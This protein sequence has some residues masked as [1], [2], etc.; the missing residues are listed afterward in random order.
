MYRKGKHMFMDV[1]MGPFLHAKANRLQNPPWGASFPSAT[2]PRS[3]LAC[4]ISVIGGILA[5]VAIS[6][7]NLYTPPLYKACKAGDYNLAKKLLSEGADPNTR[8][9]DEEAQP[10]LVAA[11]NNGN[12]AIVSLLLYH[13]AD[14]NAAG[15]RSGW[16]ALMR[17]AC[18]DR[19]SGRLTRRMMVSSLLQAGAD[20]NSRDRSGETPLVLRVSQV[21]QMP[22]CSGC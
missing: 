4:C 12:S 15:K 19:L 22:K 14:V 16:N 20:V 18:G 11:A 7:C 17:A 2:A 9:S 13:G 5:A 8:N 3:C 1:L 21:R 10:A 6:G